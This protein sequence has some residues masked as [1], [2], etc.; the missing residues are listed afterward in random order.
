MTSTGHP[1]VA[2]TSIKVSPLRLSAK[3]R[4]TWRCSGDQPDLVK[5]FETVPKSSDARDIHSTY[6]H[7]VG[8]TFEGRQDVLTKTRCGIHNHVVEFPGQLFKEMPPHLFRGICSIWEGLR[9]AQR[10]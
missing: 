7:D 6:P 3:F 8:G 1:M 4:T 5:Y 9:G 2:S 10:A